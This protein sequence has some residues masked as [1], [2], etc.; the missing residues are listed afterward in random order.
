MVVF[1][2]FSLVTY[3]ASS[4]HKGDYFSPLAR[5]TKNTHRQWVKGAF[6]PLTHCLAFLAFSRKG[7]GVLPAGGLEGL[8][9]FTIRKAKGKNKQKNNRFG[10]I[11]LFLFF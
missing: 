7:S 4:F 10:C 6:C 8:R 9:C 1:R 5:R 11:P 3:E 2:T